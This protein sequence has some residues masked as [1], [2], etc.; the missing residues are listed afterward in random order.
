MKNAGEKNQHEFI[1]LGD[2]DDVY[3]QRGRSFGCGPHLPITTIYR[4]V[5][6]LRLFARPA[7]QARV[8]F[9]AYVLSSF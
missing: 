1:A 7:S 4:Q 9:V 8:F 2:P 5:S 3:K 6:F